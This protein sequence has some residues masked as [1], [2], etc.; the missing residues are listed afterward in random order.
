MG[1]V[2]EQ[3]E[4]GLKGY[5]VSALIAVMAGASAA[6]LTLITQAVP[7]SGVSA[8]P[9]Q[10]AYAI[11]AGAGSGRSDALRE[12]DRVLAGE[13]G[14]YAFSEGDINQVLR[15]WLKPREPDSAMFDLKESPNVH[16]AGDG[17]LSAFLR[18]PSPRSGKDSVYVY[19][20]RGRVERRGFSPNMGWMGR[21]PVPFLNSLLIAKIAKCYDMGDRAEAISKLSKTA[22]FSLEAGFLIVDIE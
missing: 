12:A 11:H 5:V 1:A 18:L 2:A 14:R 8:D 7:Q 6:F 9:A 16:I 20:V 21:S 3:G 13:P 17:T 4:K 10:P 19:Q 22:R 15:A